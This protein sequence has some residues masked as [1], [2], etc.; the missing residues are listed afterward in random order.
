VALVCNVKRKWTRKTGQWAAGEVKLRKEK[1][2][3][4]VGWRLLAQNSL[5]NRKTL[6]FS[7]VYFKSN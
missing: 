3:E 5:G 7:Y 1:E 6:L 4:W 2:M